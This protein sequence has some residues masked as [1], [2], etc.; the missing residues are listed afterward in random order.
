MSNQNPSTEPHQHQSAYTLN[1]HE[2]TL[3]ATDKVDCSTTTPS[4]GGYFSSQNVDDISGGSTS[5]AITKEMWVVMTGGNCNE[6]IETGV[7]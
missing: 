2:Y 6:W 5:S 3:E 7:R 4:Y 1:P